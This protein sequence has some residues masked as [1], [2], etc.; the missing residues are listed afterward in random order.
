M[1]DTVIVAAATVLCDTNVAV[2]E[3][4]RRF[5]GAYR[6]MPGENR[7]RERNQ[8][9]L[10]RNLAARIP[11]DA[12]F[13]TCPQVQTEMVRILRRRGNTPTRARQLAGQWLAHCQAT[14]G[15]LI[16]RNPARDRQCADNRTVH[17]SGVDD[18][19]I[20]R[21]AEQSGATVVTLDR[22]MTVT[23]ARLGIQTFTA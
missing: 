22:A 20:L 4:V 14:G 23:A 12:T 21:N 1:D 8:L 16:D 15:R 18:T 6:F 3:A 17:G 9:W 19:A 13:V 7:R 11:D 10:A 5:G 2:A